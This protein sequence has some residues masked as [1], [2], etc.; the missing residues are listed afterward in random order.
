MTGRF[1][2]VGDVLLDI[3][4]RSFTP[5]A[6][7]SDA[8][9]RIR[10]LGGGSAANTAAWLAAGGAAVSF[11]SRVGDD[12]PAALQRAELE[13]LGVE[14]VFAV[15]PDEP[16]GMCCVVVTPGGARTM[17]PS[18]G[19]SGLL[20]ARDVTDERIRAAGHVH[21]SGYALLHPG[22]RRGAI[23]V[24]RRAREAGVPTSVDANSVAPI[25]AVGVE[26]VREWLAMASLVFA[27]ADEACL[28][29]ETPDPVAAA[30]DLAALS[31]QA[32]VK[33]GAAGAI[34]ASEGSEPVRASAPV[35]EVVDTTG[36]GDAFSAGFLLARGE[37]EEPLAALARGADVAGRCVVRPGARPPA[38]TVS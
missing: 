14:C 4:V 1:L 15:D 25:E 38:P 8:A 22:S 36:A 20:Q 31:G 21:V 5:V 27:N 28:L 12:E 10:L 29:A 6:F 33:L 3:V 23:S 35:V 30:A 9:S 32:V 17:F 37:G 16:T 24:L 7:G 13:A 34:F 19:A 11:A 2:V 18:V 26:R